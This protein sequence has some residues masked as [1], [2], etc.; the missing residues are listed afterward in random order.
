M[1]CRTTGHG[2][3]PLGGAGDLFS[4]AID[5]AKWMLFVLADGQT[6]DAVSLIPAKDMRILEVAKFLNKW[7]F[8]SN[9]TKTCSKKDTKR[10]MKV[11]C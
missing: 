3:A 5:M 7:P 4:S 6:P 2:I 8:T 1:I 10:A 11:K 9:R